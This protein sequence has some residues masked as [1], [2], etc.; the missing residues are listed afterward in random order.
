LPDRKSICPK[1]T[2]YYSHVPKNLFF[3]ALL[4]YRIYFFNSHYATLIA[5]LK[6]GLFALLF[7]YFFVRNAA[8]HSKMSLNQ[9][10]N[11]SILSQALKLQNV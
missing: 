1:V 7:G 9:T 6:P 3:Y 2:S 11:P 10:K 4:G 8:T 5:W